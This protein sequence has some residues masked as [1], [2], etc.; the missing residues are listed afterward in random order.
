MI[1]FSNKPYGF[2][3]WLHDPENN[4]YENVIILV[5][6][7]FIILKPFLFHMKDAAD[8]AAQELAS[9]STEHNHRVRDLWV[10]EGH[11]VSQKYGI[12]GKWVKWTGFCDDLPSCQ[13]TARQAWSYYSVGVCIF[14]NYIN[15]YL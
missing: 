14:Y 13:M 1:L 12:G 10:R 3:E 9:S 4:I 11:P 15:Y 7:D 2:N 8:K 5:D 6:P